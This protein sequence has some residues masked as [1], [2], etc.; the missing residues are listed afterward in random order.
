[1]TAIGE[2]LKVAGV[3]VDSN[4]DERELVRGV[5]GGWQEDPDTAVTFLEQVGSRPLPSLNE[6]QL[7]ALGNITRAF[8]TDVPYVVF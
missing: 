5:I 8:E 3:P 2:A 1:M 7:K 6:G 4:I